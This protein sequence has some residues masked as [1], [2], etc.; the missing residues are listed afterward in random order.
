[1]ESDRRNLFSSVRRIISVLVGNEKS[2][3]KIKKALSIIGDS[4]S[5]NSL[6]F[7]TV[8]SAHH[9]SSYIK[10]VCDWRKESDSVIC[11]SSS[12]SGDSRKSKLENLIRKSRANTV[13]EAGKGV[14]LIKSP[15]GLPECVLVLEIEL[16]ERNLS[17][18]EKDL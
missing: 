3:Q 7:C 15:P 10:M 9:S 2:L 16:H 1:M 11:V 18:E 14:L 5:V 6:T 4:L 17:V 13:S 12:R 8:E